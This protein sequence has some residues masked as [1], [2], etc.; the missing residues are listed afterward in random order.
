MQWPSDRT[1]PYGTR[2][3]LHAAWERSRQAITRLRTEFRRTGVDQQVRTMYVCGSLGRMEAVSES[4]CDIVV[5]VADDVT[6]R[7]AASEL[8]QAVGDGIEAVGFARPK[9]AGIFSAATSFEE[10]LDETTAGQVDEDL[11]VFGKR[12]QALLDGQPVLHVGEF[13]T[14]QRAILN[15]YA[16]AP[17]VS[18]NSFQLGWLVDDLVRYWRSLCA[19]TRWLEKDNVTVWRSL[20]VKLR[21]SRMLLCVGLF[22]LLLHVSD[23]RSPVQEL[24][25]LL[26]LTPLERVLRT[27][28][29]RDVE[30]RY[31]AFMKWMASGLESVVESDSAF[32]SCI[33]NGKAMSRA[34][35]NELMQSYSD[36]MHSAMFGELR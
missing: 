6:E 34:L 17:L 4:D 14:L 2:T 20:N 7:G 10:L 28:Q 11:A 16:S 15:R 19:R 35:G 1:S 3:A 36:Q 33:A 8:M 12:I 32:A 26:R 13:E 23:S 29:P 24:A 31:E 22:D 5:V 25:R 27:S 9:S 30:S 21:H 18:A